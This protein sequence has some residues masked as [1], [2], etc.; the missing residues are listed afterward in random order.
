M[1]KLSHTSDELQL[2][3]RLYYQNYGIFVVFTNNLDF[4]SRPKARGWSHRPQ[5][6]KLC[7]LTQPIN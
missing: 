4:P 2:D 7:E 1:V 3:Y 6:A 5:R